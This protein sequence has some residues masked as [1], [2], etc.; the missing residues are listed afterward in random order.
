MAT[1]IL[2]PGATTSPP[3]RAVG[4]ISL[5]SFDQTLVQKASAILDVI[6]RY[7]LEAPGSSVSENNLESFTFLALIYDQIKTNQPV[8]MCLPAFPFKS[9]NSQNKVLGRLPDK[10]EEFSL[11]HIDGLCA[12]IGDMHNPGAEL[13]IVS[14]GLVYNG[15]SLD[16]WLSALALLT[17]S[18]PPWCP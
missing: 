8:R 5:N 2:A 6:R 12:A 14:D 15:K 18:R 1:S 9:P 4:Y 16:R 17:A 13:T 11:A 7:R 10:A 3:S